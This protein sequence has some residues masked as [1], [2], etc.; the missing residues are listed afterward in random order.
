VCGGAR[1]RQWIVVKERHEKGGESC[2]VLIA[3]T[4]I[5]PL[6]GQHCLAACRQGQDWLWGDV[7]M[8]KPCV[9]GEC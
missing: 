9:S 6:W 8:G 3:G 2:V 7:V 1:L 4:C 5:S